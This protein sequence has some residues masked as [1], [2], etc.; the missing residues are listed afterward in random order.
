MF[1]VGLNFQIPIHYFFGENQDLIIGPKVE[2]VPL[3]VRCSLRIPILP[4]IL[5][6]IAWASSSFWI[7]S[8][9]VFLHTIYMRYQAQ[10]YCTFYDSYDAKF[11]AYLSPNLFESHFR[12]HFTS[13]SSNV[14]KYMRH[15]RF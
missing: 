10:S 5:L 13:L 8:F 12:F 1:E 15:N 4:Q 14:F 11:S 7:N 9:N 6:K 3:S 2:Q